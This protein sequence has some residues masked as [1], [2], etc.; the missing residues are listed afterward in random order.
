MSGKA[1]ESLYFLSLITLYRT[2]LGT[3]KYIKLTVVI[4]CFLLCS[5]CSSVRVSEV[6]DQATGTKTY[7]YLGYVEVIV[8]ETR[9]KIEAVK[10]QSL[11]L[12]VEN[13]ISL[14]WKNRE[15]VLVPLKQPQGAAT[16]FE[17]TCG[18]VVII[19]SDAEARHAEKILA[20]ME[21]ENICLASFQ[22]GD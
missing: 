20:D 14:G 21:G 17:A 1:A 10:I 2:R 15:Q 13:G 9:Q 22:K 18:L 11:G 12:A 4:L 6:G 7:R 8:P 16:P 5:A 19:R 3:L